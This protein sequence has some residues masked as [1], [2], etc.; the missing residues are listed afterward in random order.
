MSLCSLRDEV[1]V[2]VVVV[3]VDMLSSIDG[4]VVQCFRLH[5]SVDVD[6]VTVC[7]DFNPDKNQIDTL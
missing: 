2:V 5:R 6:E 1:G 7:P 4:E 3:R